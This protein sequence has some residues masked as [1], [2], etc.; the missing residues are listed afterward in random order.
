MMGGQKRVLTLMDCVSKMGYWTKGVKIP[1]ASSLDWWFDVSL[2]V[3]DDHL[4]GCQM[5]GDQKGVL[6]LMD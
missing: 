3:D 2:L 4:G 5:I 6:T 1:L